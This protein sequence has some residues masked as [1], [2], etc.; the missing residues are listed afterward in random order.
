M[1]QWN[2]GVN[3]FQHERGKK[4]S[5]VEKGATG[6]R[7][8]VRETKQNGEKVWV[9]QHPNGSRRVVLSIRVVV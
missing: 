4:R 9:P 2:W 8:K 7:E 1:R 6:K 3:E 5:V